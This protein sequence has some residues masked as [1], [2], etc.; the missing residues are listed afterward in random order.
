MKR[1]ATK[2]AGYQNMGC[3]GQAHRAPKALILLVSYE[4]CIILQGTIS[5]SYTWSHRTACVTLKT[6][7]GNA[8][9]HSKNADLPYVFSPSG[10]LLHQTHGVH[11]C[12]KQ[13][14]Q[15]EPSQRF[16]GTIHSVWCMPDCFAE[17]GT[18]NMLSS[19]DVRHH[20]AWLHQKVSGQRRAH[21]AGW[22][23]GWG[24]RRLLRNQLLPVL[25][26]PL[27]LHSCTQLLE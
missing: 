25:R 7:L 9:E 24:F 12:G 19:A 1:T 21:W 20:L 5:M 4:R 23:G 8:V 3:R 15:A 18:R 27:Q 10:Q 14:F 13:T 16:R 17:H 6:S 2:M 22:W 11:V 26:P